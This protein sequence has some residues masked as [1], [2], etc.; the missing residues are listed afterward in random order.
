MSVCVFICSMHTE[1][2]DVYRTFLCVECVS[3][4]GCASDHQTQVEISSLSSSPSLPPS[5]CAPF[6]PSPTTHTHSLTLTHVYTSTLPSWLGTPSAV[7]LSSPSTLYSAS[8]KEL[9]QTTLRNFNT[10]VSLNL[11]HTHICKHY[12]RY[13][14]LI[15]M[16]VCVCVCV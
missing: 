3:W 6:S 1:I 4:C 7:Q 9:Y 10:K 8:S 15:R 11:T 13:V 16:C 14:L 12:N 2:V 5:H